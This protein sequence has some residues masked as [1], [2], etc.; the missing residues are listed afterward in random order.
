MTSSSD[1]PAGT[2]SYSSTLAANTADTVTFADRYGYVSVTNEGTTGILSVRTDGTAATEIERRAGRGLLR[3]HA[4]RDGSARP[5]LSRSGTSPRDVI[6]QG[7]LEFGGGNT[8]TSPASPGT[9]TPMESLAGGEANPG[10]HIS[11]ISA[12]ANAYTVAAAG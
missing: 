10:M 4:G 3:R 1:L 6:L 11:I 9:V 2:T 7:E 12:S 8:A 5:T